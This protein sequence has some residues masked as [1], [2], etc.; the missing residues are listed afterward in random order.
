MPSALELLDVACLVGGQ[1]LGEDALDAEFARHGLGGSLVVARDHD[2]LDAHLLEAPKR[3][4]RARFD[5]V[6]HGDEPGGLPVDR[7]EH[8]RL[9]RLGE[10]GGPLFQ[11]KDV[12]PAL[13]HQLAVA[14]QHGMAIHLRPD[15]VAGYGLEPRGVADLDAPLAGARD[16]GL[17]QRV[18]GVLLGRGD[19]PQ[20]VVLAPAIQGEDVGEGGLT[21][22]EGAGLVED[23]GVYARYVLEG[24]RVLD[25][26]VVPRSDAGAYGHGGRGRQAQGVGAGDDDGRDRERHGRYGRSAPEEVP[27]EEG[28]DAGA[29]G[30]DH[31]VLRG[32]VGQPLARGLGVL[33]LLDE[34]HDLGERGVRAD[35]GGPEA[36][37]A[38]AVDRAGD[39]RVPGALGDRHALARHERLVYAR[40]ALRDLAV[41]GHL[42][43][44]PRARRCRRDAP[45]CSGSSP[46]RRP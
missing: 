32:A 45:R 30:Q 41:H 26:D 12:H 29:D 27:G 31:Q 9:A 21:L 37:A 28:D 3:L 40:L 36:H 43:A 33:R 34:V 24:G 18:L 17:G 19:E 2:R 1:H 7:D 15:A 46:L 13:V 10:R 4:P 39:H 11:R 44:G 14:H 16:Y 38:A 23:D 6:R 25:Q 22:G 5:G 8:R 42:V 35:G 20:E